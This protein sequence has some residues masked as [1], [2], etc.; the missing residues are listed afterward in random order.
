MLPCE[1]ALQGLVKI[2]MKRTHLAL[3]RER[4]LSKQR[5][6]KQRLLEQKLVQTKHVVR[7]FN[8]TSIS[9]DH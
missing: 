3:P 7:H 9:V 1:T 5:L 4:M 2:I 6:K 8:M